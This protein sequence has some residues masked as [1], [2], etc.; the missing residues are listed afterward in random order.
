MDAEEIKKSVRQTLGPILKVKSAMEIIDVQTSPGQIRILARQP[1][2][3]VGDLVMV[4]HQLLS[5]MQEQAEWKV[6]I[7]KAYFLKDGRVVQAVRLILQGQNP[8]Q[9]LEEVANV[10]QGAPTAGRVEVNEIMLAGAGPDRN[11]GKNGKGAFNPLTF[12]PPRRGG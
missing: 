9:H 11:S 5:R 7:S 1:Q 8:E 4:I 2:A 3:R 10:I 12:S 6:D